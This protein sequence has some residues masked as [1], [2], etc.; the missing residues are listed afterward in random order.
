[1]TAKVAA[2]PMITL[3]VNDVSCL[4]ATIREIKTHPALKKAAET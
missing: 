4:H 2:A 3:I 1:M